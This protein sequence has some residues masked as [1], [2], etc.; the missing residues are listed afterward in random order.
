V[1][2]LKVNIKSGGFLSKISPFFAKFKAVFVP[3][4]FLVSVCFIAG[5]FYF[6]F[7]NIKN[8]I[9]K[10]SL[11]DNCTSGKYTNDCM[12]YHAFELSLD[13]NK[14]NTCI[15]GTTYTD[16]INSSSPQ[17]S[18]VGFTATPDIF[19]GKDEGNGKAQAFYLSYDLSL[20]DYNSILD[21]LK[22]KSFEDVSAAWIEKQKTVV[23]SYKDNYVQYYSSADGGSLSGSAL[24]AKV[25][26]EMDLAKQQV[27]DIFKIR[28]ISY[29]DGYRLGNA[30]TM[31]INFTDYTS[32][33][34]ENFINNLYKDI[35]AK[36]KNNQLALVV[37][38]YPLATTG[39]TDPIATAIALHCANDQGK[40]WQM[41]D[42][43]YA[44]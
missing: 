1:S 31:L 39:V 11:K 35:Q 18:S 17:I 22:T 28:E 38:D 21:N 37:M 29:Q 23:D 44:Q 34:A 5:A 15:S 25:K 6:G 43:I 12:K 20:D 19:I 3:V 10:E 9:L 30:Q 8:N 24:D 36:I 4:A 2:K 41:F 16:K 42:K 14:F 32:T 33:Y 7:N 27:A 26:T 13:Y 40:V